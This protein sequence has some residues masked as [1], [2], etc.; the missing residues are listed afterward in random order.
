[1][2]VPTPHERRRGV[3][4]LGPGSLPPG[5]RLRPLRE[6]PLRGASAY[7]SLLFKL[8]PGRIRDPGFSDPILV[9]FDVRFGIFSA[10]LELLDLKNR[11]KTRARELV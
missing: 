2:V 5:R 4:E 6:E 3:D 1:M 10:I 8:R 7:A 11:H 9:I